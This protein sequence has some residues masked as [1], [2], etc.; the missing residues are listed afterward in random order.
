MIKNVSLIF[1]GKIKLFAVSVKKFILRISDE[2]TTFKFNDNYVSY[3]I[4]HKLSF[5]ITF[6]SYV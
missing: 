1:R 3:L 6:I 2:K 4:V 5:I